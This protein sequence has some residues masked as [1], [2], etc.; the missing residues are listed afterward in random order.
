MSWAPEHRAL[1]VEPITATSRLLADQLR[2]AGFTSLEIPDPESRS[3]RSIDEPYGL[4]VISSAVDARNR[5]R[6]VGELRSMGPV[7]VILLAG[8]EP[9][10]QLDVDDVD[11]LVIRPVQLNL[12]SLT[13]RVAIRQL[14]ERWQAMAWREQL[15]HFERHLS[16]PAPG[17]CAVGQESARVARLIPVAADANGP[18]LLHGEVGAGK[19]FVARLIHQRSV[20][21]GG[22]FVRFDPTTLPEE[23]A[24]EVLTG[25]HAP[26]GEAQ[27]ST[28]L[29]EL[30]RGG[31]L[32]ISEAGALSDSLQS[33]ILEVIQGRSLANSD[34]P[35]RRAVRV[36]A[37]TALEISELQRRLR[38]ELF[39][40]M[41]AFPIEVPPV[42]ARR[43][44]LPALIDSFLAE[45]CAR[46]GLSNPRITRDATEALLCWP[47]PGNI[48]ELRN[49][50]EYA[51]RLSD[52]T[53][54]T[55]NDL[56]AWLV[57]ASA[58]GSAARVM[59][60]RTN[61][62]SRERSVAR[63]HVV[64]ALQK[65]GGNRT[66][67]AQ[68]LGISRVALWKR[69]RKLELQFPTQDELTRQHGQVSDN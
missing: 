22:A 21:A 63:R 39:W 16:M 58:D 26:G 10:L 17:W 38:S 42:S 44:D 6:L 31:T 59:N 23:T 30:A 34:R 55:C 13:L 46:R 62:E 60:A 47:W 61:G 57:P 43:E 20:R 52:G 18:V 64:E 45:I 41:T 25:T 1:I 37:S 27:V 33:A 65:S 8:P 51:A 7:V 29:L 14:A 15:D 4:V 3:A 19:E 2:L 67:A 68:L 24:L 49:A 11:H 54:I 12:L 56:P 5:R 36:I 28:P 69:M 9:K 35:G 40:L 66:Q 48:R 53:I 50:L 32:Y